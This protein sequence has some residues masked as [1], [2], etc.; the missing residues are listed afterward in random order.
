VFISCGQNEESDERKTADA[1]AER[2]KGLGFEPWIAVQQQTLNGIKEHIFDTLGTSEYFIFVDFRREKI[3]GHWWAPWRGAPVYRGSLFSHQELTLAS[4]LGLDVLPF[5]ESGGEAGRDFCFRLRERD[6]LQRERSVARQD[7]ARGQRHLETGKW[8]SR[9]RGE[10]VVEG[11]T[12]QHDDQPGGRP[13][14]FFGISVRNRHRHKA[15]TTCFVYLEKATNLDRGQEI[16]LH[17]FELKWEGLLWPYANITPTQPRRFDAFHIHHDCPTKLQFS[18]MFL[19]YAGL[20]P[21]IEG[22]GRYR[23]EY[24][25]LSSN[26]PAARR[27]FILNLASDISSTTL[28]H[29]T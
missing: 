5:R 2:L 10:L 11:E 23:L 13:S 3:G 20:L 16:P 27:S 19:D 4:Y 21:K 26:F 7:R 12:T 28:I 17:T 1:I 29:A 24:L 25:V 6:H 14:K 15:A 22:E 18:T 9:W 8:S